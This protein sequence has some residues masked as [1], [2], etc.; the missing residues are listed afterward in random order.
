MPGNAQ[1]SYTWE[2]LKIECL[3]MLLQLCLL[4][5]YIILL[6]THIRVYANTNTCTH[7]LTCE[8]DAWEASFV[9]G[10]LPGYKRGARLHIHC[11]MYTMYTVHTIRRN[12]YY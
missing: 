11:I 4:I 12:D 8:Y 5:I 9:P 7:Y 2:C 6:I 1:K 10:Y 3:G